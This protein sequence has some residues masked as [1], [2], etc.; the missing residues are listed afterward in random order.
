MSNVH[1]SNTISADS[2][3]ATSIVSDNIT[4]TNLT[5]NG[6]ITTAAPS[7]EVDM[8][9]QTSAEVLCNSMAARLTLVNVSTSDDFVSVLVVNDTYSIGDL[10]FFQIESELKESVPDLTVTLCDDIDNGA[11]AFFVWT[12]VVSPF[13]VPFFNVLFH[14]VKTS[15]P[16]VPPGFLAPPNLAETTR[17]PYPT[18]AITFIDK[19]GGLQTDASHS[20]LNQLK[21]SIAAYGDKKYKPGLVVSLAALNSPYTSKNLWAVA[22][23]Q[24]G[25][26]MGV[27]FGKWLDPQTMKITASARLATEADESVPPYQ[28]TIE[29]FNAFLQHAAKLNVKTIHMRNTNGASVNQSTLA[30][31]QSTPFKATLWSSGAPLTA[32]SPKDVIVLQVA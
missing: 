21:T 22:S 23:I 1:Q 5:V 32:T 15:I 16:Y 7:V 2:V 6:T 20:I 27:I 14:I 9:T 13:P 17:L 8:K 29:V 3:T 30:A 19:R 26:V 10:V 31:V 24:D 25:V 4:F 12:G 28:R 18:R 11:F